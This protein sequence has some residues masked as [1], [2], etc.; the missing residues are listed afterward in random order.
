[1]TTGLA[2][3][4]PKRAIVAIPARNEQMRIGPCL[5]ALARQRG[6]ARDT[7]GIVVFVNGS[8]DRTVSVVKS[9]SAETAVNIRL[10]EDGAI[11]PPSAGWARRI[12]MEGAADW[13]GECE[14][15]QNKT[16]LRVILTTDAD[17]VVPP[18]WVARNLR[19]I[20]E[21]ASAV[22]GAFDIDPTEKD[23]LPLSL[24]WR[25]SL[26]ARYESLITE[27]ACRLDPQ[28]H[29]PWPRHAATSGASL[30][31]ELEAYRAV[32][33]MPSVPVGEDRAFV[34]AL[35]ATGRR[36]RHDPSVRVCTS[37][38]L[39]GR[40]IGGFS[41][42]MRLRAGRWNDPC[43]ER[44]QPIERL[45]G[46]STEG[47]LKGKSLRPTDLPAEIAKASGA[48]AVMRIIEALYPSR[49]KPARSSG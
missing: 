36:V 26:E 35:V 18:D 4:G 23:L 21:G 32:G 30:A 29:D 20:D 5:H 38:R 19:A 39:I 6:L 41:D 46:W 48:L 47:G 11:G 37:G 3:S 12:A 45:L 27:L 13:F 34:D 44:L 16:P 49:E 40:A 25:M 33:G 2:G 15:Q 17:T 14:A 7:L 42:G 31:V 9:I 1:M 43:D 10:I 24:R 28:P 22:A 8:T